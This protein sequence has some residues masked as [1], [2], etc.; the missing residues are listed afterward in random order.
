M[1][2]DL[3]LP[4]AIS[5]DAYWYILSES[6]CNNWHQFVAECHKIGHTQ[7]HKFYHYDR[8]QGEMFSH[9]WKI[10][11]QEKSTVS[12]K[13]RECKFVFCWS[14]VCVCVAVGNLLHVTCTWDVLCHLLCSC[15][16]FMF[17]NTDVWNDTGDFQQAYCMEDCAVKCSAVPWFT[18]LINSLI[19]AHKAELLKTKIS[20][21]LLSML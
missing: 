9:S 4:A 6:P 7:A 11:W 16:C 3:K 17:S 8:W 15:V 5:P 20:S 12:L 18:S 19:T 1:T 14:S 21:P 10:S 13:V 2:C